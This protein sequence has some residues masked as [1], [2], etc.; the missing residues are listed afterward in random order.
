LQLILI[1]IQVR[2]RLETKYVVSEA[3]AHNGL[4]LFMS[5]IS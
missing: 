2:D 5:K 1:S 3:A 4:V